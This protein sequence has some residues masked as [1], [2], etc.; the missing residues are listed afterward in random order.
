M[1]PGEI[2]FELQRRL[3]KMADGPII[4]QIVGIHSIVVEGDVVSVG[5]DLAPSGETLFFE[6]ERPA[7]VGRDELDEFSLWLALGDRMGTMH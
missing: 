7:Q 5:Y 1:T 2:Q 4:P 3:V 6:F